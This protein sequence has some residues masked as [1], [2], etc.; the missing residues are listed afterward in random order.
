MEGRLTVCNMSIEAGAKAG[1]I[2]PD[3]TTFAYLKGR[4]HAPAGEQWEAAIAYWRDMAAASTRLLGPGHAQTLLVSDHLAAAEGTVGRLGA[5]VEV[6]ERTLAD[7]EWALGAGHPDTL[8][9]R[10]NLAHAYQQAGRLN[11]AVQ[12]Y[13][14]ALA[15]GERYLG[16]DHP[17]TQTV[18]GNLE[19]ARRA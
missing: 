11:E 13:E 19:G 12:Q 7:R 3:E 18:R 8:A 10:G 1:L 15:D 4:D 2:A 14:R 9:A 6:H 16:P 17:M 5:A